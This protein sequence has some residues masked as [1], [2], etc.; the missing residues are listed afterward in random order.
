MLEGDGA[1][2]CDAN[3]CQH[4]NAIRLEAACRALQGLE[5]MGEAPVF[6]IANLNPASNL[7]SLKDE[8]SIFPRFAS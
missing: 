1:V 3:V 5:S 6:V 4:S 7:L 2:I 8:V